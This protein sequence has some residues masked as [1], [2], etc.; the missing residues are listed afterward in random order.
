MSLILG[1][2]GFGAVGQSGIGILRVRDEGWARSTDVSVRSQERNPVETHPLLEPRLGRVRRNI[3]HYI[4]NGGDRWCIFI[5]SSSPKANSLIRTRKICGEPYLDFS[6]IE[7]VPKSEVVLLASAWFILAFVGIMG[8]S[9]YLCPLW[10]MFYKGHF[11][12]VWVK[13]AKSV[14]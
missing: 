3:V 6:N 10:E 8:A 12:A 13:V 1:V 4:I 14:V 11:S 7:S 5:R 9:S 2:S